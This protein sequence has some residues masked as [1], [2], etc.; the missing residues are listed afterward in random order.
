[1]CL[2]DDSMITESMV[3]GQDYPSSSL[4]QITTWWHLRALRLIYFCIALYFF[5]PL[6]LR[7]KANLTADKLVRLQVQNN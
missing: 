6:C 1:M 3:S 4:P 7:K 2:Y 5:S